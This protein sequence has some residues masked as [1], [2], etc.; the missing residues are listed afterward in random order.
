MASALGITCT[1][2]F[3]LYAGNPTEQYITFHVPPPPPPP[4]SQM[5]LYCVQVVFLPAL[6]TIEA[7]LVGLLDI[8]RKIQDVHQVPGRAKSSCVMMYF[9]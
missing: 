5:S 9:F 2:V 3:V 1:D 4:R 6:D 7:A 8:P